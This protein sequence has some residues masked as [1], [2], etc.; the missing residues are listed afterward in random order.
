LHGLQGNRLVQALGTGKHGGL[1]SG[2]QR[3]TMGNAPTEVE[4]Y[5]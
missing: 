3:Q 4:G 1:Q 2:K 5:T